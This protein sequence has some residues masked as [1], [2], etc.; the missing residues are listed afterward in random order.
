MS[1]LLHKSVFTTIDWQNNLLA[2]LKPFCFKLTLPRSIF[3]GK[4]YEICIETIT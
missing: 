1:L 4:H 2:K 3:I